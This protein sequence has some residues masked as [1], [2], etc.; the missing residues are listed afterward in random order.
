[1]AALKRRIESV[2]GRAVRDVEVVPQ[3][4]SSVR[5]RFT[6]RNRGK[7][8]EVCARIMAMPEFEAYHISFEMQ[9]DP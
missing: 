5:V 8:D 6:L 9:A 4:G 2:C 7:G 3:S 1:V